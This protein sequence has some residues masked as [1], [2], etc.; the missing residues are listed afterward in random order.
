MKKITIYVE[1]SSGR[2]ESRWW[3]PDEKRYFIYRSYDKAISIN[4][5]IE[6]T[7]YKKKDCKI[8]EC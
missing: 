6:E 7:G 4:N 2:W 1:R 5:A 3:H 8:V